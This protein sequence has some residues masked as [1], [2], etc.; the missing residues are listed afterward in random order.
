MFKSSLIAIF[1][2]SFSMT[3]QATPYAACQVQ[4][5]AFASQTLHEAY[6]KYLGTFGEIREVTFNLTDRLPKV[7]LFGSGVGEKKYCL[8]QVR[9]KKPQSWDP[10]P[11]MELEDIDFNCP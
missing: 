2:L 5:L 10:C 7:V 11:Q 6:P 1:T 4:I 3:A 8:A 9:M